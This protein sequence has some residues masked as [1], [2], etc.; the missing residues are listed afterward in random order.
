[1]S[2]NKAIDW[3]LKTPILGTILAPGQIIAGIVQTALKP[4]D[5]EV[6]EVAKE[7]FAQK[8]EA[9]APLGTHKAEK[10]DTKTMRQ[11][12]VDN[13]W[14]GILSLFVPILGSI[15]LIIV[16]AVKNKKPAPN[17]DYKVEDLVHYY[18]KAMKGT[19]NLNDISEEGLKTINEQLVLFNN[20]LDEKNLNQLLDF[21]YNSKPREYSNEG[22]ISFSIIDSQQNI[23]KKNKVERRL[24]IKIPMPVYGKPTELLIRKSER[25]VISSKVK[26]D[27]YLKVLAGFLITKANKPL[28]VE[29][30]DTH[31]AYG[32]KLSSHALIE[33]K[34]IEANKERYFAT[35]TLKLN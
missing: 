16:D 22:D 23:G 34:R 18:Q 35:I 2:D 4:K 7:V 1:M 10:I 33:W 27:T 32:K 28:Q 25:E 31:D 9:E 6:K 8:S 30:E 29:L 3:I 5:A 13:I 12:G 17:Y 26:M 24:V 20:L 19:V 11:K 14:R 15:I 21:G